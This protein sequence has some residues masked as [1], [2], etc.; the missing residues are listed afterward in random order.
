MVIHVVSCKMY[1]FHRKLT[2][3]ISAGSIT[4]KSYKPINLRIVENSKGLLHN[5]MGIV[6]SSNYLGSEKI[7]CYFYEFQFFKTK[8]DEKCEKSTIQSQC[9]AVQL[10]RNDRYI[11]L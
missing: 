3:P 7:G 9:T 11:A 2:R 1:Q 6:F 8:E 4:Q 10:C 5:F